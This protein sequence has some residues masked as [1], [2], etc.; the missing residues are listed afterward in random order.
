VDGKIRAHTG[1]YKSVP[2]IGANK[3]DLF[4]PVKLDGQGDFNFAGKLGVPA[5]LDFL[6]AVPED[7]TF[8]KFRRGVG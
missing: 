3:P 1:G 4:L 7:G 6:H 5:F 8:G 2:D